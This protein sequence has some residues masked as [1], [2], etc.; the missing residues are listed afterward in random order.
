MR[1]KIILTKQDYMSTDNH[2]N[3]INFKKA[4]I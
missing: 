1:I 3:E 4:L 2:N